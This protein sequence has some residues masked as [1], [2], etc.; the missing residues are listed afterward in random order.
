M[1]VSGEL[2]RMETH[3]KMLDSYASFTNDIILK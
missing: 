3:M 1:A 2:K